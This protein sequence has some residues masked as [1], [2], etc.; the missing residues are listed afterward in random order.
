MRKLVLLAVLASQAALADP[1]PFSKEAIKK[2]Q[3]EAVR[4][5]CDDGPAAMKAATGKHHVV[6]AGCQNV[7]RGLVVDG[8]FLYWANE[9]A[10]EIMRMSRREKLPER[11]AADQAWPAELAFSKT[12]LYWVNSGTPDNKYLDGAVVRMPK[13]GGK[14]EMIV[15]EQPRASSI[16]VAGDTLFWTTGGVMGRPGT[17]MR[18]LL[19][20]SEA[21]VIASGG[22]YG[23]LTRDAS[24]VWFT[25]MKGQVGKLAINGGKAEIVA[26]DLWTPLPIVVRGGAAFVGVLNGPAIHRIAPG[27]APAMLVETGRR[28][29]LV[30]AMAVDE[31]HLYFTVPALTFPGEGFLYRVPLAG[32]ER[33][34][35]LRGTIGASA[36]LVEG[37]VMYL[38]DAVTGTVVLVEL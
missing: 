3:E 25:D 24:Q 4:K 27:M 21:E 10:G 17:V 15:K 23:R 1:S 29:G 32:G 18:A 9:R 5:I 36:M 38:S 37:G 35:L 13:A 33:Q 20:G 16:L 14:P 8:D 12:H 31:R 28:N 34:E 6:L 2:M 19:D 11:V 26:T 7:P 22:N 30:Q